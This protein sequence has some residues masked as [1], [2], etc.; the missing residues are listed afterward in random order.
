MNILKI[1]TNVFVFVLFDCVLFLSD[2]EY[3]C[4]NNWTL[5]E[6]NCYQLFSSG[7]A[8]N[9]MSAEERCLESDGHLVS[10]RNSDDMEFIHSLIVGNL[11][12]FVAK[13]LR[14]YIGKHH[15]YLKPFLDFTIL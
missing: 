10:I 14:T 12:R 4:S 13:P 1:I 9:W 2:S 15:I 5:Y 7:E 6:N 8:L 3:L 11:G